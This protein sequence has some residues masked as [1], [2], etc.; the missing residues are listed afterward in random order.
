[1]MWANRE[2]VKEVGSRQVGVAIL[3]IMVIVGL[4]ERDLYVA[5]INLNLQLGAGHLT[6]FLALKKA[7]KVACAP[8]EEI[9]QE[10]ILKDQVP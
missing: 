3:D 7:P 2:Q 4:T 1:M 9:I 8:K 6:V 5:C 10:R